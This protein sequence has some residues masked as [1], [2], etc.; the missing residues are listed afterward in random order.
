M[1]HKK[2]DISDVK[3]AQENGMQWLISCG[4]N[5]QEEAEEAAVIFIEEL[6]KAS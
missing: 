6:I 1:K 4:T 2:M 3:D 5:T